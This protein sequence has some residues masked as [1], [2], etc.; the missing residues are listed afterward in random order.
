MEAQQ[1]ETLLDVLRRNGINI[2][3][4]CHMKDMFP[5]GACRMCLVEDKKTGKLVTSCSTY[6]TEGMEIETHS[7]RVTNAR[8]VILELLLAGH[9]DDCLYCE[10]NGSCELQALS[11]ELCVHE[12]NVS[13]KKDWYPIDR[14]SVSIVRDPEKCILCGRC[15]RVCEEVMGVACIDFVRRGSSAYVGTAF[16]SGLNLSSCVNCG[17]CINVCPTG[18]LHEQPHFAEIKEAL[19]DP[20]KVVVV[21]HAPAISVS[22]AQEFGLPIGTDVTGLLNAALRKIGFNYVFD[23]AFGADLTIMEE[24]SELIERLGKGEKLPLITSCCHAWIKYAEEFYPEFLGNLSSC[25]SPQQMQGAVIKTYFAQQEGIDPEKIYSVSIMPCTA[26]KFEAQRPE[27][28]KKGITDIDAVLTT[29]ELIKFLKMFG[30]GLKQL[31]PEAADSPLGTRTSAGKLFGATGGVAEAAIRTAYWKVTGKELKEFRIEAIRGI[32]G[33]KEAK[34]QVGDLELGVAV[35]NG[36]ANAAELLEEI[37]AGRSDIQFIEIMACP[38]G[39]IGGG[40]Q[41]RCIDADAVV[42]RMQ[43]LYDIDDSDTI[44]VSHKNPEVM[45]LYSKFLGEPL[46]EKS[47]ELLHTH[48]Y[49]RDEVLI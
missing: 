32:K 41:P 27:M 38:G 47:H 35:V 34:I 17:Q 14:S 3:T 29:R 22:I 15:V 1:G 18:A 12:R 10:R 30:L 9:P 44:R 37:K 2:P 45:E 31:K 26:K 24:S 11:E 6:V 8:K 16:D 49:V 46:G 43:G 42:K 33:R 20:E 48:Y 28:T 21:Q 19:A 23:T 13:G 25:K 4:L 39:C 40:G 5:T 36:L 7:P